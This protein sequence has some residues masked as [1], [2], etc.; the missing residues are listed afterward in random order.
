MA[1]PGTRIRSIVLQTFM[2]EPAR[3]LACASKAQRLAPAGDDQHTHLNSEAQADLLTAIHDKVIPRLLQAHL[4][5]S[6]APAAAPAIAVKAR[7]LELPTAAEVANVVTLA[8]QQNSPAV[9]EII[10]PMLDRGL[11][12]E[13]ILLRL[14]APAARELGE[15]WLADTKSFTEVT[16]GLATLHEIVQLLSLR[17]YDL[18]DRLAERGTVVL[19]GAHAEQHTLGLHILGELL[20]Q[21]RW[22]VVIEPEMTHSELV[23][24]VASEHVAAVGI[25]VSCTEHLDSLSRLIETVQQFSRNTSLTVMLGGPL[26]LTGFARDAGAQFWDDAGEAVHW[27]NSNAVQPRS[28][29]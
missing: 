8:V 28:K 21:S 13:I 12:I 4:P 22:G 3:R 10:A 24:H 15:E 5:P 2:D 7:V 29:R 6:D 19:V 9:L 27:L 23:E 14:V 1:K 26:D 20:R 16:L 17:H 25:S 18:A 11:S